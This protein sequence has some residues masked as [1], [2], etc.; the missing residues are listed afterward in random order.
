MNVSVTEISPSQKK[1]QVEIPA[2]RV[3]EEFDVRYRDLAKKA[4]IPGFRPGK[5][6]RSIIK[7]RYGKMVEQEVSSEFIKETFPFSSS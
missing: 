4:K 2:P 7:S 5:V 6:P 3:Q 1:I